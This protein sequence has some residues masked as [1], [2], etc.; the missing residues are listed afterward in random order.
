MDCQRA[1]L[2]VVLIQTVLILL[3]FEFRKNVKKTSPRPHDG[4]SPAKKTVTTTLDT[5]IAD[6][7]F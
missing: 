6:E 5:N 4:A 2:Q 7:R 3:A 1:A